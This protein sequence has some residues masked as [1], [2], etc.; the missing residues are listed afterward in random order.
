MT[1]RIGGR[2]RLPSHYYVWFE[3]PDDKGDEVLHFVSERRKIKLKGHSFREFQQYVLPLLDGRHTVAEIQA[4]VADLFAPEDLEAGLK[5]L[6]EQNLLEDAAASPLPADLHG[7]L[8]PQLNFFHE[9]AIRPQQMQQQLADATVSIVGLAGAGA[10]A[11]VALA[12]AHVGTLRCID[13]LPVAAADPY[14]APVYA[15]G[16]VGGARA[17]V[18]RRRVEALAPQVKVVTHP[19]ALETDADVQAAVQGSAFVLCC[20]D[21]GQAALSYRLNRVCLRAGIRWTSCATSGLEVVVGPTVHPLETACY[22]CYKM[23]A[24]ACSHNPEQEFAFQHFLDRRKRD[25]SGR[26]ENLVFGTGLAGNLLGLEALKELTGVAPPAAVG[27][28]LVLDL[29]DL[30]LTKHLV[31]RKPWCPACFAKPEEEGGAPAQ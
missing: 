19:A 27:R 26:R 31:L 22:L 17:D 24:V 15:P 1:P 20:L 13:S 25:D 12:T 8:E 6:A 30:S 9:V 2:P 29:L 18:I 21:A 28:I 3:P 7:R 11:A 10:T 4:E 23:R 14:L 5:L 16:D